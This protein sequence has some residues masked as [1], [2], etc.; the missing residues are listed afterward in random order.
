[1]GYDLH[2]TRREHWSDEDDTDTDDILEAEWEAVAHANLEPSDNADVWVLPDGRLQ[3]LFPQNGNVLIRKPA[4][5]AVV[6]ALFPLAQALDAQIQGDDGE[7]YG[8][9]G[10]PLPVA[11][12]TQKTGWLAR[13][14]GR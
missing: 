1:M 6:A 2:M 10:D 9:D 11:V 12:T 3:G 13:L 5:A 14:F 4:D 7:V 8:P